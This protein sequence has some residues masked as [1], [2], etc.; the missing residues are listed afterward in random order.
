M[1]CVICGAHAIGFNYDALSCAP[2][3]AFFRRN[4]NLNTVAL[5]F[6]SLSYNNPVFQDDMP[7]ITKQN[8][9]SVAHDVRRKCKK[10][11]LERCFAMGMRKDFLLSEGEKQQRQKHSKESSSITSQG[12]PTAQLVNPT[13]VANAISN[14]ESLASASDEI[15]R[16]SLVEV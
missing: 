5:L 11:R 4:A 15:D 2:C 16:V 7:C 8:Q 10:C 14:L 3:K 12:L 1:T 13:P 9:C 6:P